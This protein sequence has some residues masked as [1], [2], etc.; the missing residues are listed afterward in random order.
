MGSN[1]PAVY[2]DGLAAKLITAVTPTKTTG[3]TLKLC[4]VNG[5]TPTYPT[6]AHRLHILQRTALVSKH[7]KIYVAAESSQVGQ[8]VTLGTATRA[9]PLDDGTDFTGSGTAQSFAAGADVILSWDAHDAAQSAKLDIANT[10]SAKQTFSVPQGGA[11]Y[12]TTGDLPAGGNGDQGAYVT[13]DGV[14]YDYIAGAWA[15]RGTD[16]T[17]N[18]SLTVAGKVEAG[19][20]AD[21]KAATGAGGSG[22]L[23]TVMASDCKVASAGAGDDGKVVIRGTD[24]YIDPTNHGSGTPSASTVLFGDKT[25]GAISVADFYF[26]SGVTKDGDVTLS[27]ETTLSK[28][29]YYGT[30]NLNGQTLNTNGFRIFAEVVTGS[31]KI[32]GLTGNAGGAGAAGSGRTGGGT[33]GTAGAAIAGTTVQDSKA[34]IAGGLGG[35]GSDDGANATAGAGST[36]GATT[37]SISVTSGSAGGAGGAGGAGSQ[38]SA[39]RSGG[40]STAGTAAKGY[41][42]K[43]D[44]MIGGKRARDGTYQ[45]FHETGVGA[46]GGGGGGGGGVAGVINKDGGKGGG[47]GGSGS[48]GG[49]IILVAKTIAGTF[50][51]ESIGGA[52]G[53]GG[54]G[55]ASETTVTGATG[56]GGGGG[57]GAGG[58]GGGVILIYNDKSGW[59]GSYVLTG[60]A[61]GTGAAGGAGGGTGGATGVTGANGTAGATGSYLEIQVS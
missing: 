15:A 30:L 54:A 28:D 37:N 42:L 43:Y 40:T 2:Q 39:E 12:A 38:A 13:A 52:G 32:K 26:E 23:V 58:S 60:G 33:G 24:G 4:Q 48:Q 11:V 29:M 14:F 27:V 55:A 25:W 36:G 61:A 21:Y 1:A 57:G 22:A 34:G 17:P 53:N 6:I 9:L 59:S 50:T 31:G 18:A 16:A 47:G 44:Y 5:K 49:W 51:F 35:D 3:I 41:G 10:F 45:P 56:G 46:G 20:V 8:T 19:A 7:E